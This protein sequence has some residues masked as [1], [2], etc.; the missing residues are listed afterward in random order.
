MTDEILKNFPK[1]YDLYVEGFGGSGSVLFAKKVTP[2][3]IYN[4]L[5]QNVYSL[6]SVIQNEEQLNELSRRMALLCYSEQFR[7]DFKQQLK[8]SSVVGIDR[9]LA[10]LYVSRSSFNSV[11]GFSIT[12]KYIRNGVMRSIHDY[13]SCIDRLPEIHER[14]KRVVIINRD[15]F[16]LLDKYDEPGVF[17]YLD[18]PY[19][20]ETRTSNT[21]YNHEFTIQDHERFVN[22][23]LNFSGKVLISGYDHPIYDI[24]EASGKF[25]KISFPDP[26]NKDRTECL[27]RNYSDLDED[28][29]KDSLSDFLV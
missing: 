1:S 24:L 17:M 15:I 29:P 11:G 26:N 16:E 3:E 21:K 10:F 6:F 22:R 23:V 14:L 19:V 8:D 13:L 4:D 25:M 5:D 20:S 12:H 27:W 7:E 2:A 9:A 18:P 28:S